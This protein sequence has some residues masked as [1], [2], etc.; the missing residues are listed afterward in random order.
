MIDKKCPYCGKE[1]GDL[2]EDVLKHIKECPE[3]V[4]LLLVALDQRN[5]GYSL[6]GRTC[7]QLVKYNMLPACEVHHAA[8]L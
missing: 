1:M 4:D 6:Q 3:N 8:G 2:A 5:P 7:C